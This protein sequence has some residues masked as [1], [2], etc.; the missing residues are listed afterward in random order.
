MGQYFPHKFSVIYNLSPYQEKESDTCGSYVLYYIVHKFYNA[1]C[2]MNEVLSK[3]FTN[4]LKKNEKK[5][6]KFLKL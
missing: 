1:D 4:N 6:A 2:N 3:V 5:V